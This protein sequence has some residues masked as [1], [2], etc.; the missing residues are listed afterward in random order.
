MTILGTFVDILQEEKRREEA[1]RDAKK[2]ADEAATV[3][4]EGPRPDDDDWYSTHL[5]DGSPAPYAFKIGDTVRNKI[6]ADAG[7]GEVLDILDSG[8]VRV[9]YNSWLGVCS[10]PPQEI[11]LADIEDDGFRTIDPPMHVNPRNYEPIDE[12]ATSYTTADISR[13]LAAAKAHE[14]TKY[15]A[16]TAEPE[17]FTTLMAEGA[18]EP[19]IKAE[20]A[21]EAKRIVSGARRSAYGKPEDNF[22]RIARL[23]QAHFE[24]TGRAEAK[25]TAGD[26]SLLMVLM[27]IGRLAES[28]KHYD[29]WVDVVGYALT[30]AEV[31][32]V[33]KA[34]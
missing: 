24:N 13:G 7:Y 20:I 6:V 17:D 19:D 5:A 10:D 34:A 28:P 9:K 8:H 3:A 12:D 31:N 2:R 11:E 15:D 21:D 4:V 32:G 26:I 30:G 33:E 18:K 27:K 22:E 16:M 1:E 29:S 23:W 14:K 25:V